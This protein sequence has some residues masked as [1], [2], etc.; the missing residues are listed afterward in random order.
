MGL[1]DGFEAGW[2]SFKNNELKALVQPNPV[3][4]AVTG[5][6]GDIGSNKSLEEQWSNVG[7]S[8]SNFALS[9]NPVLKAAVFKNPLDWGSATKQWKDVAD[10]ALSPNPIIDVAT[11]NAGNILGNSGPV[12]KW[13]DVAE[14]E[15]V[16]AVTDPIKNVIDTSKETV[17]NVVKGV[18]DALPIIAIGAAGIVVL[19]LLLGRR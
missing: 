2:N 14:S 19:G 17:Q 4:K 7:K 6:F 12:E 18:G 10:G 5:N 3:I 13:Q 9:P 1:F 11:G 15:P 16:K 8:V